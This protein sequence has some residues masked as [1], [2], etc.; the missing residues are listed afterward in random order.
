M[1]PRRSHKKSRAGCRRCKNRKIK[2]DEVHP[3][4]GN[5]SKHGVMCDFESRQ[6]LDELH[7]L[8]TPTT[9]SPQAPVSAPASV[10][11]RPMTATATT[12][13]TTAAPSTNIMSMYDNRRI[14]PSRL[15]P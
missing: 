2:C 7:T 3:R 12:I 9:R 15:S 8:P 4:C 1:P 13:A 6:V 5:C 10:S 11:P 14:S